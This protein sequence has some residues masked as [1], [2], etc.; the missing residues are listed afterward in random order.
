MTPSAFRVGL[1]VLVATVLAVGSVPAAEPERDIATE[2]ADLKEQVR[3]LRKELAQMRAVNE[4]KSRADALE[5]KILAD[6]LDRLEQT[7]SRLSS[8]STSTRTSSA[9]SPDGP[10]IATGNVRLVNRLAVT[11]SVTINGVTY[12]IPP[13]G[14]RTVRDLPAGPLVYEATGEGMGMG[15]PTRS[16][17]AANETLTV[18]VYP[19]TVFP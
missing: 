10:V 2:L 4:I 16:R 18:T 12:S 7:V 5:F 13:F 11:A 19:P 6:R 3:Q 1:A 17:L 8:P 14:S 9:F 15:P